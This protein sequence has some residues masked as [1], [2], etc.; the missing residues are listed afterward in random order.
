MNDKR[1]V[2]YDASKIKLTEAMIYKDKQIAS[3][4]PHCEMY[5]PEGMYCHH[6]VNINYVC[7]FWDAH[8]DISHQESGY[9]HLIHDA[10]WKGDSFGILWDK[11]KVCRI[12]EYDHPNNV[13][14]SK[15]KEDWKPCDEFGDV[16]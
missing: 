4:V 1:Y 2:E 8:P 14:L 9:C 7:P 13:E 6:T 5:I 11:C 3:M 10:D 16:K 12:N 15:I